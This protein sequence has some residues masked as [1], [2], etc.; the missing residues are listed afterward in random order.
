[1]TK[2]KADAGAPQEA[3]PGLNEWRRTHF[4]EL[5]ANLAVA[6]L[7]RDDPQASNRD[8]NEAVKSIAR[9]MGI[10]GNERPK[11]SVSSKDKAERT[12]LTAAESAELERLLNAG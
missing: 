3:V 4:A 10:M 1:M 9:M 5:D 7:I 6:R 2:K 11:E 12:E 8:R